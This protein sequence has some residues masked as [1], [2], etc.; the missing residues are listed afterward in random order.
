MPRAIDEQTLCLLCRL[1][2]PH[3]ANERFPAHHWL[4]AVVAQMTWPVCST[5][6][7]LLSML[8]HV[9][10]AQLAITRLACGR[11]SGCDHIEVRHRRGQSADRVCAAPVPH[12]DVQTLCVPFCPH[13]TADSKR[14]AHVQVLLPVCS[15]AS[16][17][18]G[19]MFQAGG[20]PGCTIGACAASLRARLSCCDCFEVCCNCAD[21]LLRVRR[22]CCHCCCCR[23]RCRHRGCG[24]CL[25]STT[26]VCGIAGIRVC[27]CDCPTELLPH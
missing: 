18:L 2:A 8:V 24:V 27:T 14:S 19:T 4:T 16:Y 20:Y 3:A 11:A 7:H 9:Q 26:H 23:C 6:S 13:A 5:A 22:G 1:L 17:M 15:S 21:C 10:A 25:F 12:A